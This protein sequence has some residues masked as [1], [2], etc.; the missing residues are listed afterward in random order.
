[1]NSGRY[2]ISTGGGAKPV[3][4]R[5]GREL[6]YLGP[7]NNGMFAVP[8]PIQTQA[9]FAW[10]NPVRLFEERYFSAIQARSYDVSHDGKRFLMIKD[11]TVAAGAPQGTQASIVV[12]LNWFEELKRLAP[13]D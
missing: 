12:V 1:V 2:L 6:F 8:I 9:T 10:G 11:G 7:D 5:D 4:S 13:R 3:W